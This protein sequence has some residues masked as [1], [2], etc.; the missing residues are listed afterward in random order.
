M[1]AEVRCFGWP[2]Q[3]LQKQVE[4]LEQ[5]L[6]IASVMERKLQQ[7]L[8]DVQGTREHDQAEAKH[9]VSL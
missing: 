6:S 7:E 3:V 1:P 5:Q 8:A 9:E 4:Q 2:L